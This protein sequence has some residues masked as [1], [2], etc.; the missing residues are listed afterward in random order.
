LDGELPAT[1]AARLEAHLRTCP[2]CLGELDALRGIG[3]HIRAASDQ[4][5]VSQDF[6]QRVL[7]TVGYLQ[8]T[9]RRQK[10][11]IRRP[12]VV[13]GIALLTLFGLVKHFL[14]EPVRAPVPAA[15]PA[16]AVAP[17]PAGVPLPTE[18]ER[19]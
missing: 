3:G 11:A 13:L 5:Y 19:R 2:H 8:V 18:Q 9:G 7:R 10:R 12:L 6:D 16:A 14:S 15:Q 1:R 4:V 17:G